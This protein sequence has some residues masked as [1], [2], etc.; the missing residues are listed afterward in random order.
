MMQCVSCNKFVLF[1][2]TKWIRK[3]KTKQISLWTKKKFQ[4]F[5]KQETPIHSYTKLKCEKHCNATSIEFRFNWVDFKFLNWIQKHW[6]EFEFTSRIKVRF[7]WIRFKFNWN[8]WDANWCKRYWKL[9]R[10]YG[11]EKKN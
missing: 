11:V 2:P 1:T 8:K 3:I 4:M 5:L 6:M 9:S 7:N 10:E